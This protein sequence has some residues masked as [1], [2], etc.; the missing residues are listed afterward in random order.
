VANTK[1]RSTHSWARSADEFPTTCENSALPERQVWMLDDD[2]RAVTGLVWTLP[3]GSAMARCWVEPLR[4]VE[5]RTR[6]MRPSACRYLRRSTQRH[7]SW[8]LL[9]GHAQGVGSG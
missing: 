9:T 7:A 5:R 2:G 4:H 1:G 6:Q 3:D 8:S